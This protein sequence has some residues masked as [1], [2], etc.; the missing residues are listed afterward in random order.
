M[1]YSPNLSN[2]FNAD[3][4]IMN[5]GAIYLQIKS[6]QYHIGTTGSSIPEL[7]AEVEKFI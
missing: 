1:I 6:N 7:R 3:V 5:N 2:M 4:Y